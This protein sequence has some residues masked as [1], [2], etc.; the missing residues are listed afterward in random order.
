[1]TLFRIAQEQLKNILKHSKA[2]QVD[3]YLQSKD[4]SVQ[5]VIKDNGIGF[6]PK[7]TQRGIGLSNIYERTRFYNGKVDIQTAPG[8]GC[9]ITLTIPCI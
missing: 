3:I 8:K 1:V 2:S 4:G 9:I 7:Q 5:L 6:D